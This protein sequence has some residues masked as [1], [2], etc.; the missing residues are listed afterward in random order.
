VADVPVQAAR[1]SARFAQRGAREAPLL[2]GGSERFTLALEVTPPPGWSPVAREGAEVRTPY[3]RYRR[4]ERVQGGKLL[5][6]DEFALE[7]GRIPPG[8][9]GAFGDFAA[10]VDEAQAQP[11]VFLG[12]SPGVA[13][14]PR[15]GSAKWAGALGMEPGRGGHGP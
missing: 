14:T 3:G 4:S 5:R 8:E 15:P 7:R 6:D 10:G 11:M 2:L 9:W 13:A 1:L 12:T